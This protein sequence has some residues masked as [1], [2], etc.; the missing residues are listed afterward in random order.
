[1]SLDSV[2][3][4]SMMSVPECIGAA[5]VDMSTGLLL[6]VS[7]VGNYE[8]GHLEYV[9]AKTADIFQ[10]PSIAQ[11]ESQWKQWRKQPQDNHHFFQEIIIV[12]D[13]QLHMFMRCKKNTDHAIVYIAR[14]TANI[15]MLIAKSRAT[16]EP[17]EKAL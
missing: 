13:N 15:G 7:Y 14:K 3:E 5:Y 9:A 10:G 8:H 2:L 12:S 16:M 4:Q 11:I 17:L 1:V 6:A